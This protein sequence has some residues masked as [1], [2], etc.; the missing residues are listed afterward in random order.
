MQVIYLIRE[1][2]IDINSVLADVN[3]LNSENE[4]ERSNLSGFTVYFP[5]KIKMKNITK[6]TEN[7]TG[8]NMPDLDF[9]QVPEYSSCTN[10]EEEV[11]IGFKPK[12]G[13]MTK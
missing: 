6:D 13:N 4:S 12:P 8:F 7:D 2:G 10:S 3:K 11:D 1:K 5:D 9:N